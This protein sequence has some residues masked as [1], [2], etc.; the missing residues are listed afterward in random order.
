MLRLGVSRCASMGNPAH[1]RQSKDMIT[2]A[3]AVQEGHCV[4]LQQ[5][6]VVWQVEMMV[7][8]GN[9][10]LLTEPNG[11]TNRLHQLWIVDTGGRLDP[12][13]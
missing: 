4:R 1:D 13:P 5:M 6:L 11:R 9:F 12:Y 2:Y 7:M 10:A 3:Q 8:I